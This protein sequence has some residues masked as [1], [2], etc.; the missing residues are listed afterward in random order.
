MDIIAPPSA[1]EPLKMLAADQVDF[2]INYVPALFTARAAGI[3][4]KAVAAHQRNL[5]ARVCSGCP[6]LT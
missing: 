2:A 1:A 5:S 6:T 3:D 4:V